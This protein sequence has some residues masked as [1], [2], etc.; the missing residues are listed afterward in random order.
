MAIT[1]SDNRAALVLAHPG[2]E[3]R[4][5]HWLGLARP[6]CFVLTDG[7]GRSGKSRLH[8]TTEILE[9]FG[10]RKG[11]IYG[12]MTDNAICSAII[13][14]ECDLFI[15][16]TRELAEELVSEQIEYVV[17]DAIEGYNPVHDLCRSMINA[18]VEIASRKSNHSILNFE[19]SVTKDPTDLPDALL[20]DAIWLHLDE[21]TLS[22]KLETASAYPGIAD[23]VDQ[24]LQREGMRAIQTE[25]LRPFSNSF[26][27]NG[28]IE[29]PYYERLGEKQVDAGYFEQVVRYRE[30]VLPLA[31]A[32]R[33]YSERER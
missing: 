20:A 15:D 2:H 23:D 9:Q 31:E 21:D 30:H 5:Y 13:R 33:H 3:L 32:L 12:R 26:A 8:S 17:G 4:V 27:G 6:L 28:F 25:C 24:I 29:P 22:K 1:F 14:G 18:A 19:I 16:L 11:C 7:S 10:A